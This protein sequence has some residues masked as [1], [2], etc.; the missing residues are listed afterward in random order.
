MNET[1]NLI[2]SELK[3]IQKMFQAKWQEF[4]AMRL[5]KTHR[6]EDSS[7]IMLLVHVRIQ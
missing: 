6:S 2:I 3:D 1:G 7:V 4:V 5:S